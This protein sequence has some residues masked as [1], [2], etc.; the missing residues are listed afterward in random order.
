[1]R[2]DAVQP[3]ED[4]DQVLH[5]GA[6]VVPVAQ[7]RDEPAG[8]DLGVG[9][10]VGGPVERVAAV[11]DGAAGLGGVVHGAQELPLR[12]AHLRARGGAAG[13]RVEEEADDE[14]VALGDQEAAELVEPEG[15]VDRGRGGG[16]EP[17]GLAGYGHG[18]AAGVVVV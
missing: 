12:G 13:R 1:M 16:E 3:P 2:E 4:V 5:R 9:H 7:G 8:E 15:A 6:L 11:V 14:G 10:D 17:G 18:V